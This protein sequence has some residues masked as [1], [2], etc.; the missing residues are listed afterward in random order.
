MVYPSAMH[1]R[2]E[3]S[4]GVMHVASQMYDRIVDSASTF[5][6]SELDYN[7]SGLA[8]D[9]VLVRI[10][11]LLHDVG[12]AP[13]SHAAEELM[14]VN[15]VSSTR[16]RH[17]DYSAALIELL[18]TDVIDSHPQNENFHIS[19]K[20]VSDFLVGR[21]GVIGR[22]LLWRELISSQ[23]DADRADYLLRDSYHAGVAYGRFDLGRLLT[24]LN[25][26][27]DPES[28][29]PV[30]GVEEGGV[31]VAEG[32]ILARYMMFTQ[33]YFQ[34]TRRSY[35]HHL[36][37]VLSNLLHSSASDD[38][39]YSDG[40]F[41][42]PTS[43]ENLHRYLTWTDWKVLGAV[44]SGDGGR[45]G[46]VLV[47]RKHDRRVHET[48]ENPDIDESEWTEGLVD[49]LES[50]SPYMD[51]SQTSW[52][53]SGDED[54][55]IILRDESQSPRAVPLSSLSNVVQHLKID[56]SVAD[57]CST[58]VSERGKEVGR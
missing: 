18:M 2:F 49:D 15:P 32:L 35:D 25:L 52:Y 40:L 46:E 20:E 30:L 29:A 27:F 10:A 13:F 23:L 37:G 17:E 16:Y 22:S 19:A 12:H 1:T 11:S 3:H 44:G 28:G 4:L 24:T 21:V 56:K 58:A 39:A 14:P 34:H 57:L 53:K 6:G 5:L 36:H 45:D 31:H 26:A 54:I 48:S 9:K 38:S 8:R 55:R 41:P 33:V 50:Y 51:S 42:G 47:S 43:A 7:S